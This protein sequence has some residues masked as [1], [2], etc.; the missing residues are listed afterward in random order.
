M[1]KSG[2]R[3][4][5]R[6]NP[7]VA[8]R[9]DEVPG[10]AFSFKPP[11][12]LAGAGDITAFA[13]AIGADELTDADKSLCPVA[14]G[15]FSPRRVTFIRA[16]GNSFSLVMPGRADLV[17][18]ANDVKA[19]IDATDDPLACAVLKGESWLDLAQELRNAQNFTPAIG[20]S[21]VPATGGKQLYYSGQILYAQD[22]GAGTTPISVKVASDQV[23]A[24]SKLGNSW[25]TCVG[26]FEPKIPCRAVGSLKHRRYILVSQVAE[27]PTGQGVVA[28]YETTEVPHRSGV[29]ADIRACGQAL[30]NLTSTICLGYQGESNGRFHLLL[31]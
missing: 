7:Y 29:A 5:Y 22:G 24:P 15:D 25:T 23:G 8:D 2:A 17:A 27:D 26:P 16:S 12:D 13:N 1:A 31:T 6:T 20:R 4:V 11:Y 9:G 19:L 21:V 18:K 30:A 10:L 3:L 28:S 14:A